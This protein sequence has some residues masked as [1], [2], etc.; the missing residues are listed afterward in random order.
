MT[1][2]YLPIKH[3]D[4]HMCVYQRVLFVDVGNWSVFFFSQWLV[5]IGRYLCLL[6]LMSGM[7]FGDLRLLFEGYKP[8]GNS[9]STD[10][11]DKTFTKCP[12]DRHW[13]T[14]PF[15][16]I[17]SFFFP[18]FFHENVYFLL[19]GR[20]S[21]GYL[22]WTNCHAISAGWGSWLCPSL[23]QSKPCLFNGGLIGLSGI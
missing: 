6:L 14:S 5:G 3:G 7:V 21:R 18:G 17:Y 19:P 20:I 15:I 23:N 11:C 2:L 10:P 16:S 22:P 13:F 12:D 8:V 9:G 1:Y 4:F